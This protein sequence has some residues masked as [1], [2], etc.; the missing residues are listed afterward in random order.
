MYKKLCKLIAVFILICSVF[1]LIP[2]LDV[3]A[4]AP[5]IT[6]VEDFYEKLSE[7][8]YKRET[9][10]NYTVNDMSL[11]K[12]IVKIDWNIY[13]AH[14][15]EEKPLTS[16]CYMVYYIDKLYYSYKGSAL[17]ISVEYPYSDIDMKNHFARLN[18]LA[19]ELKG[20]NDYET[21]KNVHDYLIDHFEYDK[22]TSFENHTDIEGFRDGVMVCSGY[23]LAAYYL[24]NSAGVK[25]R[26]ITGY[27]G[28]AFGNGENHMWNIVFVDGKWYNIDVTWDDLGKGK[29]V[30]DFFLK[31]DR[32][33]NNHERLGMYATNEISSIISDTS[34]RLPLSLT[35]PSFALR[36][37]RTLIL[38]AVILFTLIKTIIR[39]KKNRN[40]VIYYNEEDY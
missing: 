1:V 4:E 36:H 31:S 16:G 14:Y 22:K 29:K 38:A 35:F 40:Q 28:D 9:V 33:F 15:S 5:E 11:M 25:T 24:L 3:R 39:Q 27:G 26:I 23:G 21:V 2:K 10:K 13:A 32:D 34:Y 20:K 30:Y 17:R 12:E 37:M 19:D 8:I 18:R 7:Q 6:S